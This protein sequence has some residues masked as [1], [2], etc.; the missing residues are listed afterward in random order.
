MGLNCTGKCFD[1]SHV[2]CLC[3]PDFRRTS[4]VFC[5]RL[6]GRPT[7]GRSRVYHS[8]RPKHRLDL[9]KLSAMRSGKSST[10]L[11]LL[12]ERSMHGF[13]GPDNLI[14]GTNQAVVNCDLSAALS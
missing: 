4:N 14:L 10:H 9:E 13:F 11:Q 7:D 3:T 8:N 2:A 1:R 5:C 6:L 12:K